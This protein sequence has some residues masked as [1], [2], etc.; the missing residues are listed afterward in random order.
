MSYQIFEI[1]GVTQRLSRAGYSDKFNKIFSKIKKVETHEFNWSHLMHD[2]QLEILEEYKNDKGWL[3]DLIGLA[4]VMTV[5]DAILY[6]DYRKIILE[7]LHEM[8]QPFGGQNKILIC[9]SMGIVI[10]MDYIKQ[11][12]NQNIK[13]VFGF[14]CNAGLFYRQK[15]E[16]EDIEFDMWNEKNDWFGWA[17][18][19]RMPEQTVFHKHKDRNFIRGLTTAT[20]TAYWKSKKLGK[21][22][23]KKIRDM[24]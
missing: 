18:Y 22:L 5:S 1:H 8:I 15:V 12:G 9:H 24:A 14:G 21:K 20:H 13:R 23:A 7:K 2:D 4:T 11:Y 17:N 16:I 6:R 19:A 10:A 3:G